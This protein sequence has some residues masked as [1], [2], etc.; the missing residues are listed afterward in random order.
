MK[1]VLVAI[2]LLGLPASTLAQDV[3]IN[4]ARTQ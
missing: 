3:N 4:G 2:A 1:P